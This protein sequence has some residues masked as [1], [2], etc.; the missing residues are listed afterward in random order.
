MDIDKIFEFK[1]MLE[2]ELSFEEICKLFR[3]IFYSQISYYSNTNK[4]K[5][6]DGSYSQTNIEQATR[7]QQKLS[8]CIDLYNQVISQH[9]EFDESYLESKGI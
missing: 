8:T 4:G 5:I 6:Y 2:H 1:D 9:R 3:E 7:L